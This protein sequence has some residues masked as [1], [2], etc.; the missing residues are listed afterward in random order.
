MATAKHKTKRDAEWARA[1]RLCR[2]SREDV[3]MAKEMGMN[4]RKLI[5]NRASKAEPWKAPVKDWI[6][7]LHERR[8]T[9]MARKALRDRP[10]AGHA[11]GSD[12]DATS[13]S[14]VAESRYDGADEEELEDI[15][16]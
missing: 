14:P 2:L 12:P 7:D 6:R 5:R 4:P 11:G 3:R 1:K 13:A 9:K 15:P 16:F 8:Q 10:P